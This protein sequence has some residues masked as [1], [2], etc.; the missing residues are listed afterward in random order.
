MGGQGSSCGGP[1]DALASL[2]PLYAGRAGPP[3]LTADHSKYD[4]EH[5]INRTQGAMV[6]VGLTM[7]TAEQCRARAHTAFLTAEQTAD[8]RVRSM[9]EQAGEEWLALGRLAELQDHWSQEPPPTNPH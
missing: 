9:L 4:I 1:C 7:M 3:S 2:G 6:K 8:L 5:S